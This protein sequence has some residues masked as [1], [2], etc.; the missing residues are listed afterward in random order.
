M[1]PATVPPGTGAEEPAGLGAQRFLLA[2]SLG[3][4]PRRARPRSGLGGRV[5]GPAPRLAITQP[6]RPLHPGGVFSTP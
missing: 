4:G 3:G 6:P 2:A 5:P 1:S